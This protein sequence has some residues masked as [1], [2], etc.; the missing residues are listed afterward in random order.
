MAHAAVESSVHYLGSPA[1]L[2]SLE[3]DPY[4]PKWD[5]PWWHML[6]LHE[7][8]ETKSIPPQAVEAMIASLSRI[9]LKIFPILPGDM[10]EGLNL[11]RH[12]S[13]HCAVGCMYQI[14]HAY[15]VDVDA[16]LPWMRPWFLRYQMAD[17][18]LTCDNG[19]YL[20]QHECPSSMVGTIAP[21]EA[22]LLCTDRPYTP[23]EI[24]FLDR[25]AQ[26]LID[27]Q[28]MKGSHTVT[29]AEE[30]LDEP[31]WLKPCL[32]RFYLYD[33]I[34]GLMALLRW[35]EIR[36]KLIPRDAIAPVMDYLS[37]HF[38]DG[39]IRLER[40]SYAGVGS[41]NRDGGDWKR[42]EAALF[43]LLEEVS[44]VGHVS[45]VLT[46]DWQWALASAPKLMGATR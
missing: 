45:P 1:A 22:V 39:Q 18:G 5:S 32:P 16:R 8:G 6:T 33:V 38:P 7:M 41:L 11:T 10:P 23:Q 30:R 34:R 25:A 28:L 44:Q 24:D 36:Q 29:N 15:G 37:D 40:L 13:C 17:G 43:P 35:A 31:K 21:F 4:W 26:F 20:V 2:A 27:R 46:R 14:L 19:A 9:P 42:G 3:Q 12:T